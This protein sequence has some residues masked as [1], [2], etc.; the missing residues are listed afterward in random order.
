MVVCY[1][2]VLYVCSVYVCYG[3]HLYL[4]SSLHSIIIINDIQDVMYEV[5]LDLQVSLCMWVCK[6][7]RIIQYMWVCICHYDTPTTHII[8]KHTIIRSSLRETSLSRVPL[9]RERMERMVVCVC[10]WVYDIHYTLCILHCLIP[11]Y[12]YLPKY[13]TPHHSTHHII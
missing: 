9:S 13:I 10:V 12:H 7:K 1:G 3:H 4:F 6:R 8:Y 5:L 2:I 11:H